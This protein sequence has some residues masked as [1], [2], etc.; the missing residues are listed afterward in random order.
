MPISGHTRRWRRFCG[1][2]VL[3]LVALTSVA[4]PPEEFT[5]TGRYPGPPL[6]KVSQGTHELWIFGTLSVI[7]KD[8]TWGSVIV[9]RVIGRANEVLRPPGVDAW[10]RN[11]F[12][13]PTLFFRARKLTR[14]EGGAALVTVLP[15]EIYARYATIRD[16][17]D[18]PRNLEQQ[19]PAIVAGR[20]YAR[21]I[22][23]AGLTSGRKLQS[24]IE[25]LARDARVKTMDTEI[26]ADPGELLDAAEKLST[27]AEIDC[28]ATVLASIE[29]DL[30]GIADRAR[31]W[32]LGDIAA[33][34]RFDY[35]DIEGECLSFA[36]TSAVLRETMQKAEDAWL[37][38][39]V[40]ALAANATTFATLGVGDLLR[41]DGPLAR[42]RER[43]YDVREP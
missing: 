3:S 29:N 41:A 19:R 15:P 18:A 32:A 13:Y 40:R 25:R 43:G 35:P 17:Y 42:L 38:A 27:Q 7:P 36:G 16:R 24:A 26:R 33:L 11:P 34:R 28:F 37:D 20:L 2:L 23:G 30:P 31:A 8:I 12:R 6:W 14:N 4:E 9:E 1:G 22:D 21:A 10:A 5:V 39:A